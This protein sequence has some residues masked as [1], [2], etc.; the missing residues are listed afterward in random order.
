MPLV[1]KLNVVL[2]V[3]D[4]QLERYIDK[5]YD[6]IDDDN[7]Q[8]IKEAIPNDL[9]KLQI[10]VVKQKQEIAAL[11]EKIAKLEAEAK[12][13]APKVYSEEAPMEDKPVAKRGR[14]KAA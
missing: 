4:A 13:E 9:N 1:Q 12:V 7:G 14:K 2:E 11:K 6:V 8:V 10:T 3:S 5:G